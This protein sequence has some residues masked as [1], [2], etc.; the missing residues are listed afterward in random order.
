M[1]TFDLDNPRSRKTASVDAGQPRQLMPWIELDQKVQD[2]HFSALV[3]PLLRQLRAIG[4]SQEMAGVLIARALQSHSVECRSQSVT[5]DECIFTDPIEIINMA[6]LMPSIEKLV[7]LKM[8]QSQSAYDFMK[9]LDDEGFS[10]RA[11]NAL[12]RSKPGIFWSA[13]IVTGERNDELQMAAELCGK[14]IEVIG[15]HAPLLPGTVG[16]LGFALD[17]TR[18][19]V[20][21]AKRAMVPFLQPEDGYVD[22]DAMQKDAENDLQGQLCD[23]R[24]RAGTDYFVKKEAELRNVGAKIKAAR[25][26]CQINGINLVKKKEDC[27]GKSVHNQVLARFGEI[28]VWLKIGFDGRVLLRQLTSSIHSNQFAAMVNVVNDGSQVQSI[29]NTFGW[30]YTIGGEK[31]CWPLMAEIMAALAALRDGATKLDSSNLAD[32]IPFMIGDQPTYLAGARI[33]FRFTFTVDAACMYKLC[34]GPCGY[35]SHTPCPQCGCIC[36]SAGTGESNIHYAMVKCEVVK[37]ETPREFF[38]RN[39]ISLTTGYWINDPDNQEELEAVTGIGPDSVESDQFQPWAGLQEHG[40]DVPI[41]WS[42]RGKRFLRGR[43]FWEMDRPMRPEVADAGFT[44]DDFLMCVCHEPMRDMEWM[45]YCLIGYCRTRSLTETN[46]WLT[47]HKV[48]LQIE[49]EDGKMKKPVLNYGSSIKPWF[50][51][52][53]LD[54]T[55]KLWESAIAFFD[56]DENGPREDT[57]DVWHSYIAV[58][59]I[60]QEPYPSE[61][62][63]QEY[64]PRSFDY[65]LHFVLRYNP[66]KCEIFN[67]NFVFAHLSFCAFEW[68]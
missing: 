19:M 8:K 27:I 39:G 61:A 37:G 2:N 54:P 48:S 64:G 44:W 41:V 20:L 29:F 9:M 34:L 59:E 40:A 46:A 13:G 68:F 50:K 1:H 56:S 16:R 38:R 66:L 15:W 42:G 58:Q 28:T 43:F 23:L 3:M 22:L 36:N 17:T 18:V 57:I 10:S 5:T 45:L 67:R 53:P 47:A 12:I 49:V 62:R 24:D 25:R 51:P 6:G 14:P 35:S 32:L 30:A 55:K 7:K 33:K 52:D 26:R 21:L 11:R 60:I 4:G 63:R 31:S 65:F